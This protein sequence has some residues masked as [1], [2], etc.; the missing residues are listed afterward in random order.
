MM[1][2]TKFDCFY[3][4]VKWISLI[5]CDSLSGPLEFV[6]T[7]QQSD[8]RSTI[9]RESPNEQ[10]KC[11]LIIALIFFDDYYGWRPP[12]ETNFYYPFCLNIF[13]LIYLFVHFNFVK[14]NLSLNECIWS[15]ALLVDNDDSQNNMGR[16]GKTARS[17]SLL[18]DRRVT[19]VV[20]ILP[21]CTNTYLCFMRFNY[22]LIYIE[23]QNH[24]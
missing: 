23:K 18:L 11:A 15:L 9:A 10:S 16:M 2:F 12:Y 1:G 24:I 21:T 5:R 20:V 17:V 14:I 3:C 6:W 13:I 22:K 4:E 8:N 19:L 7:R